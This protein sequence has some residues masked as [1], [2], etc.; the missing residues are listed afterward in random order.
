MQGDGEP[1]SLLLG[2]HEARF[3]FLGEERPVVM[4][5]GI[6]WAASFVDRGLF[7]G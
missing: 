6:R 5:P 1:G 2:A 7:N 4:L 3:V